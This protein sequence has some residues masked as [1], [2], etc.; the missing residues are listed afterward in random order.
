[1]DVRRAAIV[2]PLVLMLAV[3]LLASLRI[4]RADLAFRSA[5]VEVS[6]WG[7]G[8]YQP[9]ASAIAAADAALRRALELRPRQAEY[10]RLQSRL[11]MWQA[12]WSDSRERAA[13]LELRAIAIL[14]RAARLRPAHTA[15]WQELDLE[16]RRLQWQGPELQ[17][18]QARLAGL[19]V[20]P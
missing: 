18:V 20:A 17:E 16:L 4:I 15:T 2:F 10:L 6:F 1:M 11:L 12:Y 8:Q 19:G 7:R 3:L 5:E 9:E 14:L 13:E